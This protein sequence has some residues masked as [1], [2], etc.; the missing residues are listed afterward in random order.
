MNHVA[1]MFDADPDPEKLCGADPIRI[2]IRIRI[3]KPL[4]ASSHSSRT[5]IDINNHNTDD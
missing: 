3:H 4:L 5:Q 2:R 1:E